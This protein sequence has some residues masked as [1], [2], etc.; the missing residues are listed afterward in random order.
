MIPEK[1]QGIFDAAAL[2]IQLF[3]QAYLDE[4]YFERCMAALEKLCRK[5]PSPLLSGSLN[6]WSAGIVYFICAQNDRFVRGCHDRLDASVVAGAFGL[7][8]SAASAK[9][10][11]IRQLF[12]AKS[13]NERCWD[14]L[15]DSSDPWKITP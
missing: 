4:R 5:R 7:S 13:Y 15:D 8:A 10:A 6:T 1:M 9:A 12:H 3:C 11:Q 14:F 2:P